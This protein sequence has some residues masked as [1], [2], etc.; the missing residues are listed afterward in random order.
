MPNVK[1]REHALSFLTINDFTN[2]QNFLIT[3]AIIYIKA[4]VIGA[5]E[6]LSA[7]MWKGYREHAKSPLCWC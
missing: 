5:A 4:V 1:G 3:L 2:L 7:I 6:N